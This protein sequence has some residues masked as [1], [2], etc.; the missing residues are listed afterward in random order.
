[1]LLQA[2]H[3][4]KGISCAY[5]G[6]TLKNQHKN[7]VTSESKKTWT[8]RSSGYCPGFFDSDVSLC[9]KC[10]FQEIVPQQLIAEFDFFCK[11]VISGLSRKS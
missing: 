1:M 3:K 6:N 4:M 2:E 9:L 10:E 8:N 7:R 5:Y 11:N